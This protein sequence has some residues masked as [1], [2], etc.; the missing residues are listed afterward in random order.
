MLMSAFAAW[1]PAAGE[2]PAGASH[3]AQ[4]GGGPE[5]R[6]PRLARRWPAVLSALPPGRGSVRAGQGPAGSQPG[7]EGGGVPETPHVPPAGPQHSGVCVW[8]VTSA[9]SCSLVSPAQG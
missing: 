7:R 1:P 2:D 5:S 3:G 6:C 9:T 8:L 4:S